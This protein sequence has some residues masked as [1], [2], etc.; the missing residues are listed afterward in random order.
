MP[1]PF[2]RGFDEKSRQRFAL[3]AVEALLLEH[4][5]VA[6][7]DDS[8]A[9]LVD[10]IG[11]SVDLDFGHLV[12]ERHAVGDEARDLAVEGVD[13]VAQVRERC[14]AVCGHGDLDR[15]RSGP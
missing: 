8:L 5:G 6:R 12:G 1:F 14:G 15:C 13:V 11:P 9:V 4:V 3:V 7:F 10:E 2:E